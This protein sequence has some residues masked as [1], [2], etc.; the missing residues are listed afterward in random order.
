MEYNMS[1]EK[2]E[3]NF[4]RVRTFLFHTLGLGWEDTRKILKM[5]EEYMKE[6]E[7]LRKVNLAAEIVLKE[8]EKLLKELAKDG[9]QHERR[10]S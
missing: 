1:D 4:Q 9:E 5:V 2:I 8:D 10:R 7:L 6:R 3:Q